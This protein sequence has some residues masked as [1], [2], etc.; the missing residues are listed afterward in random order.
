MDH[1]GHPHLP[2]I[3]ATCSGRDQG[4]VTRAFPYSSDPTSGNPSPTEVGGV[5]KVGFANL[6]S[7][8]W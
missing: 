1:F 7:K 8:Q 6:G 4:H 2:G 3:P 5:E